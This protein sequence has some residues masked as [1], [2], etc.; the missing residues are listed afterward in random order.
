MGHWSG[1]LHPCRSGSA[2]ARP[3]PDRSS[4]DVPA[5]DVLA[6]RYASPEMRRSSPPRAGSSPS[7]GCGLP[8]CAPSPGSGSPSTR[9]RS[10]TTRR[11]I[12]QVDLASIAARERVT[13]HDVKAR[14]EEF[15]ALAGH[16]NV[17]QG[18]T[19]R[20]LTENVEQAQVYAALEL[21]R[22][23][24]VAV[25]ARLGERAAQYAR[26]G[27]DRPVA[28]RP[29]AG[30]DAGQAVRLGRRRGAA[31][32]SAASRGCSTATRSA[33]SRVRSGP[34][35]TCW[36]CSAPLRRSQSWK[37]LRCRRSQVAPAL[38]SRARLGR[39]GVSAIAGLRGGVRAGP[40]GRRAGLAGH[41]DPADGRSRTCHRGFQGR[42]RSARRRCRTR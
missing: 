34:P 42:A 17:H 31:G 24:T 18:M 19:S 29:G 4:P 27:D 22:D 10:P 11:S 41:H 1:D 38:R 28:Q 3:R 30:D 21:I 35:P 7:G 14:I 6:A 36:T 33:G 25:L 15:N 2:G 39:P 20:D 40:A 32:L 16:E 8:S 12:D 13:R 37:P 23:R 5:A 9:R 26:P